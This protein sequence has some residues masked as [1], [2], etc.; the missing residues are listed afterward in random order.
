MNDLKALS[1]WAVENAL[2]ALPL[3]LLLMGLSWA[4][5]GSAKLRW[6]LGALILFRMALPSLPVALF[7][8]PALNRG[9]TPGALDPVPFLQSADSYPSVSISQAPGVSPGI[10]WAQV[11]PLVWLAGVLVVLVWLMLGVFRTASWVRS[12]R[13]RNDSRVLAQWHELGMQMGI[14]EVPEVVTLSGLGQIAVR[15]FWRPQLLVP[16][17]LTGSLTPAQLNGVLAHEMA[18]V[19]RWDVAWNW[20]GLL[21]CACQW[22][23]PVAWLVYRR[24]RADTEL[25]CDEAALQSAVAG[26][27]EYG[28]AMLTLLA[29]FSDPMPLPLSSFLCHKT[30]LKHRIQ[31][32]AKATTPAPGARLLAWLILPVFGIAFLT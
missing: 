6:W 25:I 17:G 20:L 2:W 18:H 21:V 15:G 22:F 14:R 10:V 32:I 31:M 5:A 24:L 16:A 26:R 8:L 30:D 13:V 28:E 4:R 9:E 23:N 27:Q 11:L 29:R 19:R 12:L 3:A 7:T 1:L